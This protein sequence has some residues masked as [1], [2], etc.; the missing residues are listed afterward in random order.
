MRRDHDRQQLGHAH[1]SE[2]GRGQQLLD[3]L[4]SGGTDH[5]A[6]ASGRPARPSRDADRIAE[7]R[8]CDGGEALLNVESEAEQDLHATPEA[9]LWLKV[10]LQP[11]VQLEDSTEWLSNFLE[12]EEPPLRDFERADREGHSTPLRKQVQMHVR[13]VRDAEQFFF[14]RDSTFGEICEI[15]GYDE[16]AFRSRVAAWLGERADVLQKAEAFVDASGIQRP[17]GRHREPRRE[18]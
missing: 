3:W 15:L 2:A 11:A 9:R 7:E 12:R 10:M 1:L 16:A 8:E 4:E 6:E 5:S 18:K 14:G 17:A 13:R